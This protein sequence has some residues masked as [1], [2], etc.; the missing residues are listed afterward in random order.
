MK[1]KQRLR[2]L[3]NLQEKLLNKA[4]AESR[5]ITKEEDE[6]FQAWNLELCDLRNTLNAESALSDHKEFLNT[7]V[8]PPDH[9][10]TKHKSTNIRSYTNL[11][12]ESKTNDGFRTFAEF[13]DILTS[14][15]F[16]ERMK[17]IKNTA[18][19]GTP[20]FG[21]FAVPTEY[22]SILWDHS[23]ESEIVRPRATV[24]PMASDTRKVPAFNSQDVSQDVYGFQGIWLAE[25][26]V[27]KIQTPNVRMISH[28]AKKLAIFT[29]AS[30]EVMEDGVD[31][32]TQLQSALISAIGWYLDI[33]FLHGDGIGRPTGILKSACTISVRRIGT[34]NLHLSFVD[35]AN[36]FGKLLP[37]SYKNA[38]WV[39]NQTALPS[40]CQIADEAGSYIWSPGTPLMGLPVVVTEKTP[41]FGTKGD[42]I[43]AD[44]SCYSI[45]MRK[46][47]SVDK[48]NAPGWTEDRVDLRGIIRVD[49]SPVFS[50]PIKQATG[51]LVSPFVVLDVHE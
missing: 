24:W 22:A 32:G 17:N 38:V 20:D 21:G 33:S 49:G 6:Q 27:S 10:Q 50:Q 48:S 25:L 47:I 9:G 12:T 42:V 31:F 5:N 13:F 29:A 39:V 26:G 30:R 40:L 2:E 28:T 36:M 35:I 7:P 16:D 44:F 43:L 34:T 41:T 8:T 3:L 46:D 15:R 14:G 11:F 37:G 51:N 45:G 4:K 19:I 18:S 1:N 23:L